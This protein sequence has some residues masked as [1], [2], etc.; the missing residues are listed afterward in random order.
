MS[1]LFEALEITEA[2]QKSLDDVWQLI[3]HGSKFINLHIRKDA[4]EYSFE[5]DWL[6]QLIG[7]YIDA[8]LL[9]NDAQAKRSDAE[10]RLR[11][12][13]GQSHYEKVKRRWT[14]WEP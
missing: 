3:R 7:A 8:K 1:D 9:A 4:I 11:S 12:E 5:A 6:R 10:S 13:R 14:E 2:Q